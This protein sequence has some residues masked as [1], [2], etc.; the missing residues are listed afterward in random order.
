[1]VQVAVIGVPDDTWGEAVHAVV[2]CAPDS[3][4]EAELDEHARRTIAGFKVPKQ[5]TLQSD[6]L[7]MSAAGKVLKRQLRD[8]IAGPDVAGVE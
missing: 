8:T 3:V 2:V 4:T 5:W 7:P 1:M 6:P